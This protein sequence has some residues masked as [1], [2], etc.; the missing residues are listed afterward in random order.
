MAKQIE[1]R[2][3]RY[4]DIYPTEEELMPES[5]L[6]SD[7]IHYLLEVLKWL[8]REQVCAIYTNLGFYQTPD[9]KE[10]PLIP[11]L[12]ITRGLDYQYL[13][14]WTIGRDGPPPQLVIE[15]L[16]PKTWTNDLTSKPRQYAQMG[17]QEL[18]VYDPHPK[19]ITDKAPRRLFGWRPDPQRGEMVELVPDQQGR[20]WSGQLD[21]WL[22]PDGEH[23]RLYDRN[24]QLR[25]TGEEAERKRAEAEAKARQALAEKLRSLGF[26]PDE[27]I[28]S[29]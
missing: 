26:N 27:I 8:F 2:V 4:Y 3:Q 20:L 23:L 7:L 5:A 29:Q 21:S 17:V 25:L 19:P 15:I 9:P 28:Q 12:A 22:V 10:L 14:S 18:F 24:N 13:P 1:Q 16:S 11:D 6:H